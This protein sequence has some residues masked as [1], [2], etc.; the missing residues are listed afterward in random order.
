MGTYGAIALLFALD[1]PRLPARFD[2]P[3]IALIS[4]FFL[5]TA[6]SFAGL[7]LSIVDSHLVGGTQ[8]DTVSRVV[9]AADGV[10]LL[11]L[12]FYGGRAL[13]RRDPLGYALAGL[14][15]VKTTSTFL[16]LIVNSAMAARWGHAPDG[17]QTVAYGVGFVGAL[18]LLVW[19][20]EYVTDDARVDRSRPLHQ[21]RTS[22]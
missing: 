7:W 21:E 6:L 13:A 18:T 20:L 19:F 14:L 17:V 3:P 22:C 16:T 1:L 12:L 9:I 11:P 2:R 10:V 5:V 4:A 15:L 8:L